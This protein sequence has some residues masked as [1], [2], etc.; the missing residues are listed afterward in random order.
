MAFAVFE[1]NVGLFPEDPNCYDSM[2]EAFPAGG[3]REQAIELYRKALEVDPG[4]ENSR[5]MLE[6]LAVGE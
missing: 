1:A 5:R 6:E 3:N 2:A 4:F